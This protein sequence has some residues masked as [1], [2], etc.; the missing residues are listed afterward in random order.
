MPSVEFFMWIFMGI[1]I[2][3]SH[4]LLFVLMLS[5]WI[6]GEIFYLALCFFF[7]FYTFG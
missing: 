1:F 3:P 4:P 6:K 5:L 7:A 2:A